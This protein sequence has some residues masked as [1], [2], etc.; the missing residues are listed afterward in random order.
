LVLIEEP[1][2]KKGEITRRKLNFGEKFAYT[3]VLVH[4]HHSTF[5]FYFKG[6]MMKK[7]LIMPV[8]A[9]ALFTGVQAE[10]T[11]TL[12]AT[13]PD[14]AYVAFGETAAYATAGV[15]SFKRYEAT[16]VELVLAD[17]TQDLMSETV[18][19]ITNNQSNA[20]EMT[21]TSSPDLLNTTTN[22]ADDRIAVTCSYVK[23]MDVSAGTA[24]PITVNTAFPLSGT[25][26]DNGSNEVGTFSCATTDA[27]NATAGTYESVVNVTITSSLA[28]SAT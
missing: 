23:G 18:N 7:L 3:L 14:T 6:F 27:E 12:N 4:I 8:L 2:Q 19:L 24:V 17:D 20:I 25:A 21:L 13:M 5:T 22:S 11:I 26:I 28:G 16:N 9:A 10:N 1:P 15:K